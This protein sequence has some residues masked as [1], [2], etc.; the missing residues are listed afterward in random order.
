MG[1]V[2]NYDEIIMGWTPRWFG[3]SFES[4][5]SVFLNNIVMNAANALYDSY[6]VQMDHCADPNSSIHVDHNNWWN[7]DAG[8]NFGTHVTPPC[9]GTYNANSL[10]ND[11]QLGAGGVSYAPPIE[12]PACTAGTTSFVAP[13]GDVSSVY[14]GA[15]P[16]GGSGQGGGD[17]GCRPV[18][19]DAP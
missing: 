16:C 4:G 3:S 19:Y 2:I 5:N 8:R 11:P 12:N 14:I 9:A 15:K 7:N 17:P 1:D 10:V 13:D 18:C 6:A